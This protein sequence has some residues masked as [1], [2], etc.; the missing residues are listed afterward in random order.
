LYPLERRHSF[1]NLCALFQSNFVHNVAQLRVVVQYLS[2]LAS[3]MRILPSHLTGWWPI[4]SDADAT[5][6]AA[7]DGGMTNSPWP[8]HVGLSLVGEAAT[9][10]TEA[11]RQ[12]RAFLGPPKSR[13]S[14]SRR[15]K[16]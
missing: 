15:D 9:G 13:P 4:G 8:V 16:H 1:L 3:E 10:G 14:L 12:G 7:S 6:V 11:L 5:S 2:D